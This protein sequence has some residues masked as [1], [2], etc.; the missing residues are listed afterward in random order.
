MKRRQRRARRAAWLAA[1]VARRGHGGEENDVA[2]DATTR[3]D[4]RIKEA[5]RQSATRMDE[6][7]E[8]LRKE[9]C[10]SDVV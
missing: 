1:E 7:C 6:F 8:Q 3:T 10:L 2:A 9:F 4:K 5:L